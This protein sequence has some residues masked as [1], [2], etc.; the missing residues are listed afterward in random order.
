MSNEVIVKVVE[1]QIGMLG[2]GAEDFTRY[3]ARE[4]VEEVFR[5]IVAAGP[6]SVDEILAA[7][8]IA[9]WE[10]D[11]ESYNS[12]P[13]YRLIVRLRTKGMTA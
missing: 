11:A 9:A 13:F 1:A 7:L 6:V 3:S 4:R 10:F 5:S 8:L 2:L 12:T